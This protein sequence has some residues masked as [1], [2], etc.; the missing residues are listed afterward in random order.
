MCM[1]LVNFVLNGKKWFNYLGFYHLLHGCNIFPRRNGVFHLKT[2]FFV[3]VHRSDYARK[4]NFSLQ[5]P[6][7]DIYNIQEFSW[8]FLRHH[9]ALLNARQEETQNKTISH[10]LKKRKKISNRSIKIVYTILSLAKKKRNQIKLQKTICS[11]F[12]VFFFLAMCVSVTNLKKLG[13]RTRHRIPTLNFV[14]TKK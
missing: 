6:T 5:F 2:I 1:I 4:N 10:P 8:H 11:Y 12:C 9:F 3:I 7:Q 14:C 13:I